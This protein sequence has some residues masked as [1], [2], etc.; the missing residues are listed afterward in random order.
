MQLKRAWNGLRERYVCGDGAPIKVLRRTTS[1]RYLD[2]RRTVPGSGVTYARD[3]QTQELAP[4]IDISGVEYS[5]NMDTVL[6]GSDGIRTMIFPSMVRII[7]QSSFY[8][9]ESLRAVTLNE[10]LEALGTDE[11]L[12]NWN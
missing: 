7:R 2:K 4:R 10:G 11:Y 1:I 6:G 9:V 8:K 12:S 3:A 5:R